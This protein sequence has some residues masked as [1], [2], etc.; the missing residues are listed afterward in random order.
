MYFAKKRPNFT[1]Q[2]P[3]EEEFLR[4]LTW[5][6]PDYPNLSAL[7]LGR[8]PFDT[9]LSVRAHYQPRGMLDPGTAEALA[10][11]EALAK[12]KQQRKVNIAY[13][14]GQFEG[15][16]K[17]LPHDVF[18]FK[19]ESSHGDKV[20][21]PDFTANRPGELTKGPLDEIFLKQFRNDFA[22]DKEAIREYV[23][24]R[25][26]QGPSGIITSQEAAERLRRASDAIQSPYM[27]KMRDRELLN[28]ATFKKMEETQRPIEKTNSFRKYYSGDNESVVVLMDDATYVNRYAPTQM[29]QDNAWRIRDYRA[30]GFS[31]EELAQYE[32]KDDWVKL[33]VPPHLAPKPKKKLPAPEPK[34]EPAPAPTLSIE[35]S[36]SS[37]PPPPLASPVSVQEE[38]EKEQAKE[39]AAIE[40]HMA[41]DPSNP[42]PAAVEDKKESSA[43]EAT[44][45]ATDDTS[46]DD[47]L[48]SSTSSSSATSASTTEEAETIETVA[49]AQQQIQDQL[50]QYESARVGLMNM[51]A[52]PEEARLPDYRKSLLLQ[53]ARTTELHNALKGVELPAGYV[54]EP[55]PTIDLPS[56]PPTIAVSSEVAKALKASA[57]AT[58]K[59]TTTKKK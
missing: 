33:A 49:A 10:E 20:G 23:T 18:L 32:N 36:P 7:G 39:I 4:S 42:A 6:K 53:H 11:A 38:I 24:V 15:A 22:R 16:A 43:T 2:L 25:G 35:S 28:S 21:M 3:S 8:T 48:L 51:N 40:Q 56:T 58:R 44:A 29:K 30:D 37:T 46:D 13:A 19:R 12:A 9:A 45:E 55:V 1:S 41:A 54:L 17:A 5:Q 47:K 14:R 59:R 26:E 50:K 34:P 27:R 57:T 31:P 52:V